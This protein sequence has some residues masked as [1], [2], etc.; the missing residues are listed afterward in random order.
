MRYAIGGARPRVDPSAI[1]AP[2]AVL[3]GNVTLGPD[4]YVS[5]GATLVGDDGPVVVGSGTV[6]REH[7]V[8]RPARRHAVR[9][10]WHVLVGAH[11]ALYGCTVDDE[12]FLATG[13]TIFH[14]ARIGA[15]DGALVDADQL[16][17]AQRR[18]RQ[19]QGLEV[20][21]VGQR[22]PVRQPLAARMGRQAGEGV[23]QGRAVGDHLAVGL[24]QVAGAR[25]RRRRDV[26]PRR[27]RHGLRRAGQRLEGHRQCGGE[28][29]E[30]VSSSRHTS[31]E[32][33]L[34]AL[35]QVDLAGAEPAAAL[36]A[37]FAADEAKLD[38]EGQSFARALVEGVVAHLADLD[39]LI[40]KHS[41]HWRVERMARI[42]R[43]VLRLAAYELRFASDTPGRVVLNEAVELGKA[44][45]S[46]ESSA[47]I[48]A[49]LDKVAQ[50][51]NRK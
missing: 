33:A 36:Q 45:G 30:E 2:T 3:S 40:Q 51:L 41:L 47:F 5:F 37:A 4:V 44:Y 11:S 50:E 16:V 27:G 1:V 49:I 26:D 48:N 13:V 8:I 22:P 18:R 39:A 28:G 29:K 31:R 19:R 12:A 7:V 10:G 21:G 25:L 43:N 24:H 15:L 14:G 23:L 20:P 34:Q 9:I 32:R 6:I 46:G 17:I 42:D 35:Y 38:G